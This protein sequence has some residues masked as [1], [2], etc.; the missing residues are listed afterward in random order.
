MNLKH[1]YKDPALIAIAGGALGLLLRSRLYRL[2]FDD[3]GILPASHP[4]HIACLVLAVA[5]AVYLALAVQKLPETAPDRSSLRLLPGVAAGVLLLGHAFL[6]W[7]ESAAPL[8]LL[9]CG[10]TAAAGLA[11]ALSVLPQ[12]K[13]RNVSTLCHG[14]VCAALAFDMLGRYQTWS[15]N[16]QLP[17][18]ALHVPAGVALSLCAYQTLA[19][20]TGLSRA[21]FRKFW[22]LLALFLCIC[23]LSGPE[24]WAFYLSGALWAAVCLLTTV[25]QEEETGEESDV[26]A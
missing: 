12:G 21:G 11:M 26:S 3:K 22:G 14:I 4:L 1:I 6:L 5:M 20:H 9:R 10:L 25:P 19:M 23:C 17:D 2:G 15:G 16:P 8:N 18:Y 24:H 13:N 7:Q